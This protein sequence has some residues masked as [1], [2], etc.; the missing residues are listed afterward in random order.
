MVVMLKCTIKAILVRLLYPQADKAV[1]EIAELS[2][3]AMA[4]H[5][6]TEQ[7]TLE[8][9]LQEETFGIIQILVDKEAQELLY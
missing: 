5:H 7:Q 8:E 3:Q 2:I 1:V 9:V 4:L 6:K